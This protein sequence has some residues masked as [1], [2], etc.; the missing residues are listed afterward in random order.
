MSSL[1][2]S[3]NSVDTVLEIQYNTINTCLTRSP[4]L[5]AV[6]GALAA[7]QSLSTTLAEREH[8]NKREKQKVVKSN[9]Q[10]DSNTN[11][12]NRKTNSQKTSQ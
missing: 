11:D 10:C 5:K 8:L 3:E 1:F 9:N 12:I 6:S 7:Q 4:Q 2:R